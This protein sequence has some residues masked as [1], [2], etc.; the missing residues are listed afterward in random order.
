MSVVVRSWTKEKWSE[1]ATPTI[2]YLEGDKNNQKSIK[3][4]LKADWET[5][6]CPEAT[7]TLQ[8]IS[9]FPKPN[10]RVKIKIVSFVEK[11][12]TTLL[13]TEQKKL[14]LLIALHSSID[15]HSRYKDKSSQPKS[16]L[17]NERERKWKWFM[18]KIFWQL[19]FGGTWLLSFVSTSSRTFSMVHFSPISWRGF[20]VTAIWDMRSIFELTKMKMSLQ[21]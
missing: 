7:H 17:M 14:R 12:F 5:Y 20:Y 19:A 13:M 10:L 1:E 8:L 2:N 9:S 6:E 11:N 18:R 15:F 21:G 16:F 4:G 3:R